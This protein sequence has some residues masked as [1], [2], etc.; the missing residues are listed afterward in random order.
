MHKQILLFKTSI[1]CTFINITACDIS[2][3]YDVLTKEDSYGNTLLHLISYNNASRDLNDQNGLQAAL[4][5]ESGAS[6][7]AL[8]DVG[9]TPLEIA[10]RTHNID[11][12]KT[13]IKKRVTTIEQV[14]SYCNTNPHT[15]W[16]L[17][18]GLFH[19]K[20]MEKH[21]HWYKWAKSNCTFTQISQ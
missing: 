5:L 13:F 8:N 7:H 14:Q 12:L 6:A 18:H 10:I 1:L 15:R 4:L 20:D 16:I 21:H 9:E 17:A 3:L 19:A 2:R 11:V